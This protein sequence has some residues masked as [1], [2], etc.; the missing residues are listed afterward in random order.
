MVSRAMALGAGRLSLSL[1]VARLLHLWD[2]MS[3]AL[4]HKGVDAQ[5]SCHPHRLGLSGGGSGQSSN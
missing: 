2:P 5:H 3:R 4:V 1:T